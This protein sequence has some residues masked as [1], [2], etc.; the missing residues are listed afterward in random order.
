MNY[1]FFCT[2]KPIII[3]HPQFII[4][5]GLKILEKILKDFWLEENIFVPTSFGHQSYSIHSEHIKA[6]RRC[7]KRVNILTANHSSLLISPFHYVVKTHKYHI[8]RKK[9]CSEFIIVHKWKWRCIKINLCCVV[10]F[11]S[12]YLANKW[13]N[14]FAAW[15]FW[16]TC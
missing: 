13:L 16:C 14:S 5:L 12:G 10:M 6:Y 2:T 8:T 9:F 11:L 1:W 15:S 7:K 3:F 4:F